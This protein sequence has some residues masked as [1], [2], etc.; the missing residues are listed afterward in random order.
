MCTVCAAF[1]PFKDGCDY[2]GLPTA[3]LQPLVNKSEIGASRSSDTAAELPTFSNSQIANVLTN[4]Y[5]DDAGYSRRS[6][7]VDDGELS[8]DLTGLDADGAYLARTALEAWTDVSGIEFVETSAVS[9]TRQYEGVDAGQTTASANAISMNVEM[10]GTLGNTDDDWFRVNLNAGQT[11][12]VTLMGDESSSSSLTDPLLRVANSSGS[13]IQ[14]NDDA[15]GLNSQITFTASYTGAHFLVADRFSGVGSGDY[16]LSIT[17]NEKADIVFDDEDSGG[18]STSITTGDEIIS[19]F[20]NVDSNWTR[21]GGDGIGNEPFQVY[22]HEVGHALGLGHAGFYNGN[23]TYAND[24]HYANDSWQATVMSYFTQTEN[25]AITGTFARPTTTMI[26]DILAIQDLYGSDVTTREGDTVYGVGATSDD[27]LGDL[28]RQIFNEEPRDFSRYG[29]GDVA[30][31]IYDTGGT[32]LLDFSTVGVTQLIDLRMEAISN[33]MG[34]TG[35][36]IIGPDTYIENARGGS[37]NDTMIGNSVDNR[38]EGNAGDDELSGNEGADT[39]IG[40]SGDDLLVGGTGMDELYGGDNADTL[41]GNSSV[42]MLYGE[43]GNDSLRGG[44]GVDTLYGGNGNDNLVG[45]DGWDVLY[46]DAGNDELFGSTGRDLLFGGDDNDKLAGGTGEDDL[47]GGAGRDTLFGNQGADLLVGGTGDDTLFGGSSVDMLYGGDDN[48]TLWGNDGADTL[49][50]ENGDDDLYGGTNHDVI[51]GGEG[52]DYVSGASGNDT[53]TGGGGADMLVGGSGADT[54]VFGAGFGTDTISD[55]QSGLDR[56]QLAKD[57]W[58]DE[59]LTE[60]ELLEEFGTAVDSDTFVIDFSPNE[61][62][63]IEGNYGFDLAD[64]ADDIIFI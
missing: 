23:G 64:L 58:D 39:L 26:A 25:T 33:T 59:D 20:V 16:L 9:L 19:S 37:G 48:D 11:Y 41:F 43:G 40:G 18:Y 61:Q 47:D 49:F 7:D 32:D 12:T 29:G 1:H 8:V 6:F 27:Y 62:I 60:E 38:L 54:F 45:N 53:L 55:Y 2:D 36:I 42:D 46:G 51:D 34:L 22:M 28:M 35:N 4:D 50:G 44:A 24:A 5:W 30:M 31:T 52:D 63:T 13:T 10:A 15:I 21:T 17:D 56:I 57:V 14:E 3:A